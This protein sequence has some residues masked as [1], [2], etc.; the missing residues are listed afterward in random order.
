MKDNFNLIIFLY[1]IVVTIVL[2]FLSIIWSLP[3]L[4]YARFLNPTS[5]SLCL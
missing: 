4:K 1:Q 5:S 2:C 3:S